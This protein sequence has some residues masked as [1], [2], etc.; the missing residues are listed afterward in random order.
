[1][2]TAEP[3]PADRVAGVDSD[4]RWIVLV[5]L[6]AATVLLPHGNDDRRWNGVASHQDERAGEEGHDGDRRDR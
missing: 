4:G 2:R 3:L 5:R 6:D 1:M